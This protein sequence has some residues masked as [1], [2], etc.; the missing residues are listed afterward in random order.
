MGGFEEIMKFI[1]DANSDKFNSTSGINTILDKINEAVKVEKASQNNAPPPK[2]TKTAASKKAK[3]DKQEA[4][5][6]P[7]TNEQKREASNDVIMRRKTELNQT[8]NGKS[9][10]NVDVS[11][12]SITQGIIYAEI[13]GKPVSKRRTARRQR[14]NW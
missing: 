11:L 9:N 7:P 8:R 2:K 13:L 3:R 6:Q 14:R 10:F 5:K 4:E 12:E 1:K